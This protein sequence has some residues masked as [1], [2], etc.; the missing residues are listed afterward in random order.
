[1]Y[2]CEHP[3]LYLPGTGRASEQKA[4]SGSVVREEFI[5][6]YRPLC[7]SEKKKRQELKQK[8]WMKKG[9]DLPTC[10]A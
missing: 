9:A 2:D 4:L 5:S 8:P 1:M 7:H 3:L 10:L 6:V